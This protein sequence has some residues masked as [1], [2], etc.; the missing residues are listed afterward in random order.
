[1]AESVDWTFDQFHEFN[2][3]PA[4]QLENKPVMVIAETGWPTVGSNTHIKDLVLIF[5]D[6]TRALLTLHG[7]RGVGPLPLLRTSRYSSTPSCAEQTGLTI[8]TSSSNSW[9]DCGKRSDLEGLKGA[10]VC[11]PASEYLYIPTRKKFCLTSF[12]SSA[13]S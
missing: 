1:V 9:M 10:G 6:G 2:V 3:Q 8:P 13:A 11:L 7:E 4:S 5:I 12:L